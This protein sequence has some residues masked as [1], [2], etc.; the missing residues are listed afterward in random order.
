ML[1]V[2]DSASDN[3][4]LRV[5]RNQ[6][7]QAG[8]R[9]R[10]ADRDGKD[11]PKTVLE[12]ID[13]FR[14]WHL[15]TVRFVQATLSDFFHDRAGISEEDLPVTSRLKTPPAILAKLRR[16][17]TSLTRMQDIAGA[18]IVVPQLALQD[19]TLN[20]VGETL[21]QGCVT[22]VKDQR[23]EPDQWGYR[24]IHVVL[25]VEQRTTEV[26]IRTTWQDRW[27]QV[28]ESLDST[29]G[30]DLKHGVGPADWLE[31]LHELG[32]EYRKADLG[33]EF[34][35]PPLPLD[36]ALEQQTLESE[37]AERGEG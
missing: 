11:V 34:R 3:P 25:A 9:V 30:W 6:L 8:T 1:C 23:E 4:T 29:Y 24:A 18:R 36:V 31:W 33:I 13:A 20:V 19:T 21:F 22:H 10:R 16:S 2:S 12:T 15:P 35:T 32:D 37:D 27:A 14:E 28:V 17:P 26:Q 7:D 5:R